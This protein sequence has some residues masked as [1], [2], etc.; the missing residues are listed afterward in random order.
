MATEFRAFFSPVRSFK[1]LGNSTHNSPEKLCFRIRDVPSNVS[2]WEFEI[3]RR[4]SLFW[5]KMFLFSAFQAM[6]IVRFA[7]CYRA[8][9]SMRVVQCF[10]AYFFYIF[11]LE[12]EAKIDWNVQIYQNVLSNVSK[13]SRTFFVVRRRSNEIDIVWVATF[14]VLPGK[15]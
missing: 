8:R 5:T 6:F 14:R 4:L 3:V 2:L 11:C 10:I 13:G 12:I 9:G 1:H 15:M 7:G